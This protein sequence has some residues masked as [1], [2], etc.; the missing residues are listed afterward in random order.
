MKE[1]NKQLFQKSALFCAAATC[2]V[3]PFASSLLSLFS[4]LTIL[5]W[6]LSGG[7]TKIPAVTK[8]NPVALTSLLLFIL[9]LLGIVYSSSDIGYSL[10]IL[11]KYREIIYIPILLSLFSGT[12]K[13]INRC[14]YSFIA[15]C[16][17]L[18][19]ISYLMYFS[20]IPSEKYGNSTVYHITHSYFMAI[21][22]F[23]SLHKAISNKK[24]RILWLPLFTAATVNIFYVAPGRTGML[25]FLVL[26]V[27]FF[28]QRLKFTY[29]VLCV[30]A[31]TLAVT[32]IFFT[33]ENFAS[34]S[35]DAYQ[36]II[37]YEYGSATTSQGMRLDWWI[38]GLKLIKEKPVL[39]HGT[40]SYKKEHARKIEGTQIKRTDNPHN[41]YLF[42]TVQLGVVGLLLYLSIFVAQFLYSL[43]NTIP[44]RYLHQ[45]VIVAM[46][47]GCLMNSFLFDSH[48][49]HFWA[50]LTAVYCSRQS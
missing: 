2:F 50:F 44:E 39:G 13:A 40:G 35:K 5:F 15:G 1:N 28:I 8:Q 11:K 23:F 6:L 46:M 25:I 22:A 37:T 12:G 47:T 7:F 38:T 42:I 45:G 20:I 29:M 17:F 31:F 27:L 18:L 21:L 24:Y 4:I 48:Q 30:T 14:E 26:M 33:S 32:G 19:I 16:I 49:G 3:I 9:F 10:E 36:D 43:Q 34:R 41:E